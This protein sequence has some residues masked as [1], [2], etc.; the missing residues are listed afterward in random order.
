M[1]NF[2]DI[3][4]RMNLEF[5]THINMKQNSALVIDIML[6]RIIINWPVNN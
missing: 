5:A 2:S 4:R 1:T 3:H 6:V